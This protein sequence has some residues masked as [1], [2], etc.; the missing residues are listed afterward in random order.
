V[1]LDS[2]NYLTFVPLFAGNPQKRP[3]SCLTGV[4]GAGFRLDVQ[5]L[6]SWL[7]VRGVDEIVIV[8]WGSEPPLRPF[9]EWFQDGRIKLVEV[10][11][12]SRVT[13]R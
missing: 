2:F 7:R 4:S 1:N 12:F 9:I 8:D 11:F 3:I 10:S 5:V 13:P 6:P